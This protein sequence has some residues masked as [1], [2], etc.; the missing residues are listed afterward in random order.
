MGKDSIKSGVAGVGAAKQRRIN[1]NVLK[2]GIAKQSD[3]FILIIGSC[4]HG[5]LN[6]RATGSVDDNIALDSR[7]LHGIPGIILQDQMRASVKITLVIILD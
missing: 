7:T 5:M 3:E 2:T 4:R 6:K 1:V